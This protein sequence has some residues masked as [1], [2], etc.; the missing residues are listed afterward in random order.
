MRAVDDQALG[1]G[2]ALERGRDG[3]VQ[4]Q[5]FVDDAVEVRQVLDV[6]VAQRAVGLDE[7][8]Q[9]GDEAG[10]VGGRG[11]EVVE[12]VGEGGG[13]GVAGRGISL[14]LFFFFFFLWWAFAVRREVRGCKKGLSMSGQGRAERR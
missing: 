7:R 3:R 11:G 8:A 9:L 6:A 14:C 10:L 5:R 12:G 2:D 1:R 4:A 13:G